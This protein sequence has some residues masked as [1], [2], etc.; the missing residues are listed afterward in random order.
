MDASAPRLRGQSL[1]GFVA[2][3]HPVCCPHSCPSPHRHAQTCVGVRETP[4]AQNALVPRG[5]GSRHT[6]LP[7]LVGT[8]QMH[9]SWDCG[10]PSLLKPLECP[11]CPQPGGLP[12][13]TGHTAGRPGPGFYCDF[14]FPLRWSLGAGLAPLN[15]GSWEMSQTWWALNLAL[16]P[17]LGAAG[18]GQGQE[19]G[20]PWELSRG[21]HRVR[22]EAKARRPGQDAHTPPQHCCLSPVQLLHPLGG[23]AGSRHHREWRPMGRAP[24]SWPWRPQ[25]SPLEGLRE[26]C[27]PC[28]LRA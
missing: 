10:L 22:N 11:C 14:Y 17:T 27:L 16:P 19:D 28:P 21:G 15:P 25:K 12:S 9:L 3:G 2:T 7:S 24:S 18:H 5:S 8:A 1:R 20:G 4:Q 6:R 23:G 26:H 13:W